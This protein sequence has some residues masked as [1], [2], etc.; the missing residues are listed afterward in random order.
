MEM[1]I[2][3]SG[4]WT[5][6]TFTSGVHNLSLFAHTH[7][8]KAQIQLKTDPRVYT[9]DPSESVK[10]YCLCGPRSLVHYGPCQG[11]VLHT[12]RWPLKLIISC[13]I[14]VLDCINPGTESVRACVCSKREK[15]FE[16]ESNSTYSVG[17]VSKN[18]LSLLLLSPHV[19]DIS[20]VHLKASKRGS[21]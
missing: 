6:F 8:H 20:R 16:F 5:R 9:R 3:P 11:I 18:L 21:H 13:I 14:C 7:T 2:I 17:K 1:I 10:S 12:L 15:P 4:M 19:G